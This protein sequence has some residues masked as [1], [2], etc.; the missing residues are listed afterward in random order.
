MFETIECKNAKEFWD[1]LAPTNPLKKNFSDNEKEN[2]L[3]RGQEDS[4]FRLLPA[5]FRPY[6]DKNTHESL[7][8]ASE[9]VKRECKEFLHFVDSE[10][11]IEIVNKGQGQIFK[12]R[13]GFESDNIENELYKN[14][15]IWPPRCIYN[16]LFLAQHHGVATQLLDWSKNVF[17]AIYFA[18]QPI[19][20][21]KRAVSKLL[22]GNIAV[23]CYL[24]NKAHKEIIVA[25][26][27]RNFDKNMI[28]QEGRFTL[29][30]QDIKNA[31][32]RFKIKTLDEI[33][34]SNNLWKVTVPRT[35]IF[36][37]LSYCRDY[38]ITAESVYKG[39]GLDCVAMAYRE[40]VL[41]NDRL[42]SNAPQ[43]LLNGLDEA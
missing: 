16:A 3:Y 26:Y 22:N 10:E 6:I 25:N 8:T 11:Y 42:N 14:P 30:K 23:W 40:K 35:E 31:N 18:C 38:K 27:P 7:L 33:E 2:L 28:A 17:V 32:K 24:P 36:V 37:L 12:L 39:R 5:A 41:L 29:V 19:L 21:D 43:G 34:E 1:Y 13:G 4:F 20:F 9:L 15:S